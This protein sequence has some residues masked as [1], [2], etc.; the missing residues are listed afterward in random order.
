MGGI[1]V[2][3]K[4]MFESYLVENMCEDVKEFLWRYGYILYDTV[5]YT[6]EG[7]YR[8][9]TI[10]S[11]DDASFIDYESQNGI[12]IYNNESYLVIQLNGKCKEIRHGGFPIIKDGE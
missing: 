6:H 9:T 2:G 1:I 8:Y 10:K 5:S 7:N 3:G 12:R 4:V 11:K